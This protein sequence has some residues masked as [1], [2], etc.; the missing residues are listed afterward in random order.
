MS[1]GDRWATCGSRPP[2][3]A[4]AKRCGSS[5]GASGRE[6]GW[7]APVATGRGDP[8][9]ARGGPDGHRGQPPQPVRSSRP[10]QD[11]RVRRLLRG[12]GG[13]V[14]AGGGGP[15]GADGLVEALRER[16]ATINQIKATRIAGPEPLRAYY[17]GLSNTQLT[18]TLAATRPTSLPVTATEATAY[19]LR[20]LARRYRLLTE[21]ITDRTGHVR[22]LLADHA[23]AL[24]AVFGATQPLRR[25]AG[26]LR[27]LPRRDRAHA[28][29][30]DDPRLRGPPHRRRPN[31]DGDHPL[32]QVLPRPPALATDPR[33]PTTARHGRGRLTRLYTRA[34]GNAG[35]HDG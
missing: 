1:T 8:R 16:T 34:S 20:V 23:S 9:A 7:S 26:Q 2:Q 31:Q 24:L 30:P 4:T 35:V 21:Q 6:G 3:P 29:R 17:R 28:S 19:A 10:R 13:P 22:R 25:P 18:S 14:R 15:E 5:A 27:A 32:P 33:R 11:R 12:R